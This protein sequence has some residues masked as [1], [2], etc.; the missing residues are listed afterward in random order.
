MSNRV[1]YEPQGAILYRFFR[2]KGLSVGEFSHLI[3][4]TPNHTSALKHYT[5]IPNDY[6]A[7]VEAV[8][9]EIQW[10][11]PLVTNSDDKPT[12][13]PDPKESYTQPPAFNFALKIAHFEGELYQKQ[14]TIDRLQALVTQLKSMVQQTKK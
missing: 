4:V 8:Y 1:H 2:E 10:I 13:T 9:P 11:V 12:A 5:R 6:K 7:K 3:G 14:R